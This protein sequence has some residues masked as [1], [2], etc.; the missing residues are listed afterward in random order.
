MLHLDLQSAGDLALTLAQRLRALR[1]H[2]SWTQIEAASRAGVTLASYKR[3]ERTGEIA[4]KSLLKINIVFDQVEHLTP[5]FQ[6]PVFRTL[7]EA[8]AVA[9]VRQR[10]PR[11]RP[12]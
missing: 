1:L 10:A 3:F 2:R 5:L 6:L 7:D 8:V 4:L 11:R 9:P 12:T